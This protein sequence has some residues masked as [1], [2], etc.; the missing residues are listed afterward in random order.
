MLDTLKTLSADAAICFE[1]AWLSKTL[2]ACPSLAEWV[3]ALEFPYVSEWISIPAPPPPPPYQP[4]FSGPIAVEPQSVNPDDFFTF[5][6]IPIPNPKTS[7]QP[8][9]QPRFFRVVN[10]QGPTFRWLAVAG[11]EGY[12]IE[13]ATDPDFQNDVREIYKGDALTWQNSQ[14]ATGFAY[15]RVCAYNAAGNSEWSQVIDFEHS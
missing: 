1:Q 10:A 14:P 9:E 12:I 2:D 5:D 15:Y 11:A 7:A 4:E 6:P 13:V 8:P 3:E